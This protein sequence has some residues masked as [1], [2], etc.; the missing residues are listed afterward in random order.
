M[1]VQGANRTITF[2]TNGGNTIPSTT[3]RNGQTLGNLPTP[4]RANH[5][6]MG[7]YIPNLWPWSNGT[8]VDSNTV[9]PNNNIILQARW[10]LT[11][12]IRTITLN[13][14]TMR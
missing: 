3:R 11:S 2:D 7:W 5:T 13:P 9:M 12:T 6:F 14:I 8:S 1:N 4:V 10:Q